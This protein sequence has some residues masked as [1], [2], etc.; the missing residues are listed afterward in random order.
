MKT[1]KSAPVLDG[2]LRREIQ[3]RLVEAAIRLGLEAGGQSWRD[4]LLPL[5]R[6][7]VYRVG[8]ELGMNASALAGAIDVGPAAIAQEFTEAF[9]S[10][11]APPP[12]LSVA[13]HIVLY[14][15]KCPRPVTYFRLREDIERDHGCT[16]QGLDRALRVLVQLRIARRVKAKQRAPVRDGLYDLNRIWRDEE[17][18]VFDTLQGRLKRAERHYALGAELVVVLQEQGPMTLDEILQLPRF[19][20]CLKGERTASTVKGALGLMVAVEAVEVTS[21]GRG[22]ER[23]AMCRKANLIPDDPQTRFHV[24]VLR[25]VQNFERALSAALRKPAH[26]PAYAKTV[27]TYATPDHIRD[28]VVPQLAAIDQ[29]LLAHDDTARDAPDRRRYEH[30]S[31]L[32]P[33]PTS[34]SEGL[35]DEQP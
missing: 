20:G 15:R 18:P 4:D 3:L 13:Q 29:G 26:L 33:L 34:L 11:P 22:K 17:A 31:M 27:M 5:L 2:A 19:Q 8:G 9:L 6:Q 35:G 10:L 32:L 23:Y 12:Q 28:V 30:L 1:A 14:L 21:M 24:G 25:L 16:D 7:A